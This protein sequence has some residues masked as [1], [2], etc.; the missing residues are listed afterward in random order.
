MERLFFQ[1]LSHLSLVFST[2]YL[3]PQTRALRKEQ[4][5]LLDDNDDVHSSSSSSN[6]MTMMS[7]KYANQLKDLISFD[8]NSD[9]TNPT[10][11]KTD[12]EG[13]KYRW[14]SEVVF[15]DCWGEGKVE[16]MVKTNL[17]HFAEVAEET[18]LVDGR[19]GLVKRR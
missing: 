3:V 1:S 15:S 5:S 19:S 16:K 10:N 13:K 2:D 9:L 18:T 7:E 11:N 4:A 14:G 6:E 8:E 12:D 17:M